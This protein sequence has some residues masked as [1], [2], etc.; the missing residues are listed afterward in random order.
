MVTLM[1]QSTGCTELSR[2]FVGISKT[3][4]QSHQNRLL[5]NLRKKIM[6]EGCV[7]IQ[8]VSRGRLCRHLLRDI[9]R[10]ETDCIQ[11]FEER[12][13]T[14]L[15]RY[16]Q[17]ISS[18]VTKFELYFRLQY[19]TVALTSIN[20]FTAALLLESQMLKKIEELL[21]SSMSLIDLYE[22]LDDAVK[23]V[24]KMDYTTQFGGK[25]FSLNYQ[26]NKMLVQHIQKIEIIGVSASIKKM[27]ER[28]IAEDNE[29]ILEKAIAD[30]S[31]AKEIGIY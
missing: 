16:G 20:G 26:S 14:V 5:G 28:G 1:T 6:D 3:F 17:N 18:I 21:G 27:F 24:K 9:I 19:K 13:V 25:C 23:E 15:Q 12:N 31:A 22:E 29:L 11:A 2:C 10:A 7:T 30:L 8:R 4:Y